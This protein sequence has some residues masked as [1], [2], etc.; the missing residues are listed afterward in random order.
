LFLSFLEEG[1]FEDAAELLNTKMAEVLPPQKLETTWNE[2][3][4]NIGEF[5][6]LLKPELP[7]RI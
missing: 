5:K 2:L 6:E 3:I 4:S 7:K 1:K